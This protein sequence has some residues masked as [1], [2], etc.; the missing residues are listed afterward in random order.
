MQTKTKAWMI[1]RRMKNLTE[2]A[3]DYSPYDGF[4][5]YE[6]NPDAQ[7]GGQT[8]VTKAF[9]VFESSQVKDIDSQFFTRSEVITLGSGGV[10][11][12]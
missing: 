6:D 9:A 12:Q 4:I 7:I 1:I 5:Y 8:A 2:L 10:V 11:S 3:R